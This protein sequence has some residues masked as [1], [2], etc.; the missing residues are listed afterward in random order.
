MRTLHLAGPSVLAVALGLALAP[1]L[2]AQDP[3][4]P[5]DTTPTTTAVDSTVN[6]NA[7]PQD[8]T[9]GAMQMDT[10]RGMSG[11]QRDSA[12]MVN[13]NPTNLANPTNPTNPTT[14][15]PASLNANGTVN[16]NVSATTNGNMN[17]SGMNPN[18]TM[19]DEGTGNQMNGTPARHM[20]VQKGG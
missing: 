9:P 4:T 12:S 20:R 2:S 17:D 16:G 10:T 11:M 14:S 15:N 7:M 8:T 6:M 18:P 1:R 5:Q 19:N 13:P 3:T